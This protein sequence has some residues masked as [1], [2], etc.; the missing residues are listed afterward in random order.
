VIFF[1][2]K[3][4]FFREPVI[5]N[6]IS[7]GACCIDD[8][9]FKL[10]GADT[11]FHYGHSC[12]VPIIK[13][14]VPISY[15]FL[16]IYFDQSFLVEI[17]KKNFGKA[18]SSLNFLST[19]Q[20]ISC[21]KKIE[22]ELIFYFK[23]IK[24]PQNKPLSPGETLGCTSP[25]LWNSKNIVYI[26]DGRF[27]LESCMIESPN[28]RFFQYNP[29]SHLLFV[30]EFSIKEFLEERK[31][32]LLKSIINQKNFCFITGALGR[33]GDA[34]IFKKIKEIFKI[35]KFKFFSIFSTE[36][37][38]DKLDILGFKKI[39]IFIQIA[40]PRLSYDWGKIFNFPLLT[41]F[42]VSVLFG[43]TV[44]NNTRYSMDYFSNS[45][46]FWTTYIKPKKKFFF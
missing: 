28:S 27:H 32:I 24:I 2:Q 16:E 12:L 33:Q 38:I 19:I 5:S 39:D 37:S 34:N 29:F 30:T 15:I 10:V 11:S 41:S 43:F 31:F 46:G 36:I 7:F 26:G 42:E 8:I 6:R 18:E 40:C 23:K 13:C 35:K 4:F 45:G 21:F 25:S 1:F 22:N 9:F 14:L 20:F 17:L 44:L 3:V